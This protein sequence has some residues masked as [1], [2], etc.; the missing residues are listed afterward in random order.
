[1][2]G[3]TNQED[4]FGNSTASG[5]SDTLSNAK[6][7]VTDMGRRSADN[8]INESRESAA[9][10]LDRTASSLHSSAESVA[11]MAHSTADSIQTAADYVRR[12]D[13]SGMMNDLGEVVKRY[14]GQALAAAAVLGF[15][16]ARGLGARN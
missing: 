14:P 11:G 12:T 16:V 10:A 1:M 5:I 3:Y 2:D 15:L 8:K 6:E 7:K 13:V 4:S 9:G